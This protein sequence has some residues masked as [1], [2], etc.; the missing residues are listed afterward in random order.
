MAMRVRREGGGVGGSGRG[1]VYGVVHDGSGLRGR[2]WCLGRLSLT[3][4]AACLHAHAVAAAASPPLRHSHHTCP[5][6]LAGAAPPASA[7]PFRD[8]AAKQSGGSQAGV[9]E[10]SQWREARR[11]R[12]AAAF[13]S[14][15][16]A[17]SAKRLRVAAAAAQQVQAAASA[18]AWEPGPVACGGAEDAVAAAPAAAMHQG[19]QPAAARQQQQLPQ[20]QLPPAAG[21]ALAPVLCAAEQRWAELQA[22]VQQQQV[23]AAAREQLVAD[24]QRENAALVAQ[25]EGLERERQAAD[26]SAAAVAQQHAAQ[27]SGAWLHTLPTPRPATPALSACL[28]A[29]QA[30]PPT[31]CLSPLPAP[32]SCQ[33]THAPLASPSLQVAELQRQ[34]AAAQRER[35]EAA[36]SAAAAGEAE[37]KL[38]ELSSQL[39]RW[40]VLAVLPRP[41][42]ALRQLW[43]PYGLGTASKHLQEASVPWQLCLLRWGCLLVQ[44]SG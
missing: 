6:P 37:A 18:P 19:V 13:G 21:P 33:H 32:H 16:Q 39:R 36:R 29:R 11:S 26:L 22:V 34:L 44:G 17:A 27:V 41:T 7:P 4:L 1:V 20:Q 12:P 31:P 10:A 42:G 23:A 38:L 43:G 28:R 8:A 30:I 14:E 35:D 25:R 40:A 2:R 24:L 5:A 3:A 15:P 9:P